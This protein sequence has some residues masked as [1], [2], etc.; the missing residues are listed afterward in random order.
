LALEIYFIIISRAIEMVVV[1]TS[2]MQQPSIAE[3]VGTNTSITTRHTGRYSMLCYHQLIIVM[4]MT[5]T[6]T[7][8]DDEDGVAFH[9]DKR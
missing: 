3:L 8:Y 9:W 4:M 5:M 6:M 7:T 1:A 2:M